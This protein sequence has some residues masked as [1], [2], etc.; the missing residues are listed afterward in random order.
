MGGPPVRLRTTTEGEELRLFFEGREGRSV[1][2]GLSDVRFAGDSSE[3]TL[4]LL[5][6][7]GKWF[8][9]QR[10]YMGNSSLDTDTLPSTG[11]YSLVITPNKPGTVEL[12]LAFSEPIEVSVSTDGTPRS[13]KTTA[14]GQDVR[15]S[16]EGRKWH[17]ISLGFH[18]VRF[19]EGST[20]A[21]LY[22]SDPEGRE[23]LNTSL[24][25]G[26]SSFDAEPLAR[27]GTYTVSIDPD[28]AGL[29]DFTVTASEPV[30]DGLKVGGPAL[31]VKTTLRG[32]DAR[33][34]FEG[35]EGQAVQLELSEI[36]YGLGSG[37]VDVRILSP[38]AQSI[39][40]SRVES[41]NGSLGS[42]PLP[43]AGTY[44]VV[45]NPD[46]AGT[47]ELTLTLR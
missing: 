31:P 28:E 25:P 18:D 1:S 24:N 12:S 13:V 47:V 20:S 14:L 30:E 3:A 5:D 17:G 8:T 29:I 39:A 36:R 46:G 16:L 11:R 2:L 22:I 41:D 15:L 33:L 40:T 26:D 37:A 10:V 9:E 7:D 6:P 42:G 23:T 19:G 35:R 43:V 45:I 21:A 4:T 32:Q 27:D 38:S 44:Y 34:S